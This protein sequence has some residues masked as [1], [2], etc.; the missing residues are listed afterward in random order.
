MVRKT[1]TVSRAKR[2]EI[3][4]AVRSRGNKDTELALMRV[5]RAHGI[6]GWRRQ[7]QLTL[8]R[9]RGD[10]TQTSRRPLAADSIRSSSRGLLRVRPDFVFREARLAVFVDGCFW[11]GCPKHATQPK[12]NAPFWRKKIAGNKTRDRLVTRT[13]RRHCWRVLR[14]WEH[15]LARIK[16]HSRPCLN[17][18]PSRHGDGARSETRLLRRI[19]AAL[20][21]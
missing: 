9:S 14:I 19:R 12:N 4:R 17:A 2:S 18:L 20:S 16:P 11:H 13:L 21:G 1:D 5:F 10:E 8:G 6:A 15:E 3:M 7:V